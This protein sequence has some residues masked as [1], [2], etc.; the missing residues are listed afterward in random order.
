MATLV[1]ISIISL[2]GIL[3]HVLCTPTTVG[4]SKYSDD[5]EIRE[6]VARRWFSEKAVFWGRLVGNALCV[7]GAI[8]ILYLHAIKPR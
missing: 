5:F 6:P 1:L 2:T 3:L 8:G 4:G 7:V